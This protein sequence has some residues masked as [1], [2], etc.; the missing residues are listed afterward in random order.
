M[1]C[2]LYCLDNFQIGRTIMKKV[3]T[4]PYITVLNTSDLFILLF[5]L[6]SLPEPCYLDYLMCSVYL[7]QVRQGI[8][9]KLTNSLEVGFT[10]DTLAAR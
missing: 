5:L 1:S 9:S 8:P 2:L 3:Q 10:V 4:Y 6:Y 7:M